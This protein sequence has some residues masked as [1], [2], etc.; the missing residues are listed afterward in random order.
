K[1]DGQDIFGTPKK[2][3]DL[4]QQKFNSIP[5]YHAADGTAAAVALQ[6]A[7]EKAGSVDPAKV[8]DALASLDMMTFYGKIKFDSRGLNIYKPMVVQ[9]IQ[10][11]KLMTVWPTE[12]AETG[13]KYPTPAWSAR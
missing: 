1:Y 5:D 11:G 10:S 6:A 12:V 8:R 4:Y 3:F 13:A 9:Q 2:Y 7:I